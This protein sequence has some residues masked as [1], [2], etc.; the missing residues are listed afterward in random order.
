MTCVASSLGN[1]FLFL[2]KSIN[3]LIAITAALGNAMVLVAP[4]KISQVKGATS[5]ADIAFITSSS[6]SA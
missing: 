4:W 6:K 2:L 5:P 1:Q 3:I